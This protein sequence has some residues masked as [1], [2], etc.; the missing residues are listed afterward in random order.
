MQIM[1]M[2]VYYAEH[3]AGNLE[4]QGSITFMF[5]IFPTIVCAAILVLAFIYDLDGAKYTKIEADIKEGEFGESR[6]RE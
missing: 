3:M 4:L 2:T 1:W 5:A 6:E